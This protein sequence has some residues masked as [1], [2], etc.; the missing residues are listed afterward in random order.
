[1][2]GGGKA[3]VT[4]RGRPLVEHALSALA[5]VV[6]ELVVVAKR[7]TPLPD[8]LSA[9]VWEDEVED[10][11]PRHGIVRAL[12]GAAG[13]DVLVLAVDLPLMDAATLAR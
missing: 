10:H 1:M 13:A 3:T 8:A 4:L 12:R 11:H 6:D 9:P 7:A 5:P 2:G